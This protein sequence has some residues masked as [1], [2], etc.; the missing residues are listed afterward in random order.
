MKTLIIV[1]FSIFLFSFTTSAQDR[2]QE[3]NEYVSS[4]ETIVE[5]V[6][7]GKY[8]NLTVGSTFTDKLMF[9]VTIT[10]KGGMVMKGSK[11]WL[12]GY[13]TFEDGI[14]YQ[15]LPRPADA[16]YIG[17]LDNGQQVCFLDNASYSEVLFV[18]G[19]YRTTFQLS[20]GNSVEKIAPFE[21]GVIIEEYVDG[22][23]K[24][25]YAYIDLLVED[26]ITHLYT[27]DF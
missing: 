20:V 1:T 2:F 8:L 17:L 22:K 18:T 19:N 12:P 7:P 24:Y 4:Q 13:P 10:Y 15:G 21:K 5:H 16:V 3:F 9:N 26:L 23:K 27:S 14:E 11:D 6:E 25:T